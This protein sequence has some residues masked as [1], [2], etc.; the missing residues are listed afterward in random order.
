M[1]LAIVLLLG[2]AQDDGKV[3]WSP[4]RHDG[5]YAT[6]AREADQQTVV[7]FTARWIPLCKKVDEGPFSSDEVVRLS[8]NWKCVR[9][10]CSEA[11]IWGLARGKQKLAG[12]PTVRF[13]AKDGTMVDE[14]VGSDE[15]EVYV[16][17]L[18]G[19][20]RLFKAHPMDLDPSKWHDTHRVFLRNGNVVDGRLKELTEASVAMMY[21]P[22]SEVQ[23]DRKDVLRV[24]WITIRQLGEGGKDIAP[25][26]PKCGGP[27][28]ARGAPCRKCDKPDAAKCPKC[29]KVLPEAGARCP[30]CD[31]MPPGTG[32]DDVKDVSPDAKLR[33]DRIVQK[34]KTAADK[35]ELID[36]ISRAG[37]DS[38]RYAASIADSS[39]PEVGV[40][41]IAGIT[42]AKEKKAAPVLRVRIAD[43]RDPDMQVTMINALVSLEDDAATPTLRKLAEHANVSVRSAAIEAL[44]HIGDRQALRDLCKAVCDADKGVR[45]RAT[46]SVIGL[47]KR[48]KLESS[49][50]LAIRSEA[51][52]APEARRDQVPLVLAQ[53]GLKESSSV[54]ISYL[55]SREMDV[56]LNAVIALGDLGAGDAVE[57]F[58]SLLD[59]ERETRVRV[60]ICSALVRLKDMGCVPKLI[61]V[62]GKDPET[63]VKM[64]AHRGLQTLTKQ[65][66]G[67]EYDQWK[68]WWD[69][70]RGVAPEK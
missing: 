32:G 65:R 60:Q 59:V 19:E 26:C 47:A 21:D 36:E 8:A 4:G 20:G 61:E 22:T 67:P 35:G 30:D 2:L 7:Y 43:A 44:G 58:Y 6:L 69:A 68:K 33:I 41:L 55:R 42:R 54:L 34:L 28:A 52:S 14:V 16:R 10:D 18:K 46:A 23:I 1:K 53:L 5:D 56:R 45:L 31:T 25:T 63:E 27:V 62:L 15:T 48:L 12:I 49:V 11:A 37:A 9:V 57:Y 17:K 3:K 40:W 70:Q 64:S 66:F 38:L 13:Y 50:F 51:T 39:G 29:G 24:E